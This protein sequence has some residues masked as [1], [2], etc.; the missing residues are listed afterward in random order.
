MKRRPELLNSV[1]LRQ[2]PHNVHEWHKRVKLFEGQPRKQILT[3]TEAVTTVDV[4]KAR[5]APLR[6]ARMT[7]VRTAAMPACARSRCMAVRAAERARRRRAGH[8]QGA[9]A[10]GG[11][12]ALLRAPRR[13]GQRA[14]HL[15]EGHAGAPRAGRARAARAACAGC[16]CAAC[17]A[18]IRASSLHRKRAQVAFRYVD[19]LATVWC[20]WVEM[21]LRRK[22]FRRALDLMR[23][24][25]AAPELLTRRQ[26][27][28]PPGPRAGRHSA[29]R[30]LLRAGSGPPA[31]A[32]CAARG[33]ACTPVKPAAAAG[34]AA[35][36]RA[37][38]AAAEEREGP[39]QGRLY[40]SSRLWAFYC[41]LE[42]SLGTPESTRGVYDRILDLRIATPQII[43]NYAAFLQARATSGGRP[44]QRVRLRRGVPGLL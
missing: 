28:R 2:N 10:V 32:R 25:T 13:P 33:A 21:E 34:R 31:P 36:A 42:E 17:A 35:R 40:R 30:C 1:M 43:L 20:E 23:R 4:A 44:L 8:G 5:R 19:D 29:G 38:T 6:A 39:V 15:R 7:P 37:Q 9:H 11:L 27:R 22:Q 14:R 16:L 26:A 24:A 18:C 3:F 12:R 41:D